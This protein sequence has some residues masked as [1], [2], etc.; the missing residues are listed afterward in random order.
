MKI[1]FDVTKVLAVGCEKRFM[2][3][4]YLGYDNKYHDKC[5][6]INNVIY[7]DLKNKGV[8]TCQSLRKNNVK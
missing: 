7:Q 4:K 1:E 5:V 2:F 3:I 8:P 6:V